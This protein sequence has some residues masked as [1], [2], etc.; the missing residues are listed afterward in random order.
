MVTEKSFKQICLI[1]IYFRCFLYVG[2][3]HPWDCKKNIDEV[4]QV[5]WP[6]QLEK[7]SIYIKLEKLCSVF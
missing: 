7:L 5:I 4:G 1:I 6:Y 2:V 3:G